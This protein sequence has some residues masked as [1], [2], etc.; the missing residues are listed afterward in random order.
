MKTGKVLVCGLIAVMLAFVFF[1]C[2]DVE[3]TTRSALTGTVS[4][5]NNSPQVGRT[6]TATYSPGNGS[7]TQ[8][9]QWFRVGTTEDSISGAT[10]NTYTVTAA[11]IG[12]KIKAQVSFADQDGSVS[13]TTNN[14]VSGEPP[15]AAK[16][17][18]AIT[19]NTASV[20]T[21]YNKGETLNLTGLVVTASYDNS[22][23]A[24]V[25]NYTS[26]PA[27]GAT[28]NTPGTPSVTISYTE[29]GVTKSDDFIITVDD[30][31]LLTLSGD[32][33]ITHAG[34]PVTTGMTLTA[35]YSGTESVSFS[36]QWHR[37]GS[38]V[39]SGG[40]TFTPTTAGSYTVTISAPGYNPK[41][42]A[43][44]V[45]SL[46][47]LSGTITITPNNGVTT[48]TQ[49]TAH[50]SGT[51][52]ASFSYQW[53]MNG[54]NVG[55]GGST[56]TPTTAGSCTVTV[57]A[58]G[59]NPKTS[60][61]V[62]VTAAKTLSSISLIGPTKTTYNSGET[63]DLTG[64]VVTARYSDN[65]TATVNY[66]STN[67]A[68]GAV[69][70]ATTTVTVSYTE[71][72]VTV[73]SS[74]T[75][76]VS[77]GATEFIEMVLVHSGTFQMGQNGNGSSDNINNAHQVTLTKNFYIGKYE[78][79]QKQW[80]TVMG[81][82]PENITYYPYGV[83]D[84]YP[85]YHVSWYNALVFC[86]KLSMMEDLDP[87]Y[88]IVVDDTP[89]TDPDD[90][91]PV[92]TSNNATWN[93]VAVV[94]GSN[95]Y[96]LPTEA[97]WEYAAKGGHSASNPPKIYSGSDNAD[98]V[99]WYGSSNG[100]THEVGTKQPNELGIYDMSGNVNE[101]CSGGLRTYTT[102]AQ[103]D[104]VD[105]TGYM[106]I[107]FRGGNWSDVLNQSRSVYR[108]QSSSFTANQRFGFR[109]VRIAE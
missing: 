86:N 84:N 41:T 24:V 108:N 43:P 30:P 38:N 45:V 106:Y 67:P 66:T 107:G 2:K 57:S 79:T 85:I 65:T 89:T 35:H 29:E 9:W 47:N 99:A 48:G 42:S 56:Y 74:F 11:D 26:S 20:K 49:L 103:T 93:A 16:I 51:E 94:S 55:S 73:T 37:D 12:K 23:S 100:T 50:Y 22:T 6:I 31:N 82:L 101:W 90:W 53:H 17:L 68:N 59:Y 40:T 69:L 36:Y 83:G 15:P 75:V 44:V 91:G 98:D 5:S 109:V 105:D 81:S 97:Q 95:G 96:R 1:A 10:S 87:A 28:L 8:T 104:P 77:G 18:T 76:T 33:T 54:G 4:L 58:P 60:D 7:G 3:S 61:P 64:L 52:S 92:P 80:Q 14:A 21:T 72:G 70:T 63:L 19:L 71:G 78:V 88:S 32:I 46:P 34:P 39:G 27:H 13:R 102:E 62:T 25:N